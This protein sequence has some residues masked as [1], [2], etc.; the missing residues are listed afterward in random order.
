MQELHCIPHPSMVITAI[1]YLR[2]LQKKKSF[3]KGFFT[4]ASTSNI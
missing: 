1:K 2:I 4:T 3:F